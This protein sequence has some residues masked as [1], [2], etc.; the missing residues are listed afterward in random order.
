MSPLFLS[1]LLCVQAWRAGPSSASYRANNGCKKAI[2]QAIA[3][4]YRKN[5]YNY[6]ISLYLT[7]TKTTDF[8]TFGA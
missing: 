2:E 3:D 8:A 5:R 1:G 6:R 7:N 4:H